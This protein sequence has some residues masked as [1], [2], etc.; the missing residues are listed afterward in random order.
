MKKIDKE[1]STHSFVRCFVL[2][3]LALNILEKMQELLSNFTITNFV[4]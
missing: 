2:I 3:N 4:T 1:K